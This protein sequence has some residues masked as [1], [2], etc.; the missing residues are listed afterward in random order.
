MAS[1]PSKGR[2]RDSAEC[3]PVVV[4]ILTRNE[5]KTLTACSNQTCVVVRREFVD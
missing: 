3:G 1:E 5:T 4:V 2:V